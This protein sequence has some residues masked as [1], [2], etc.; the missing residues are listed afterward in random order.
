[1]SVLF[2]KH[3]SNKDLSLLNVF[4]T[5]TSIYLFKL[6][7]LRHFCSLTFLI[8]L[9]SDMVYLNHHRQTFGQKNRA[10]GT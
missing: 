1:M 3:Y 2:Y 7:I 8:T 5:E 4:L 10:G 9:A 6:A